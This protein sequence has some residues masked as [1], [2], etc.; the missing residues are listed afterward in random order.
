MKDLIDHIRAAHFA[1]LLV[2]LA[3]YVAVQ[4]P[5]KDAAE[6]A[7]KDALGIEHLI[8]NWDR[9]N[10]Q[11]ASESTKIAQLRR[12]GSTVRIT[13]GAII[14]KGKPA[15]QP[16]RFLDDGMLLY[17][18][19]NHK[20]YWLD[21]YGLRAPKNLDEFSDFWDRTFPK[22]SQLFSLD[23]GSL[24]CDTDVRRD[25]K[26]EQ[27]KAQPDPEAL[28]LWGG[29]LSLIDDRWEITSADK[30]Y[31]KAILTFDP[32]FAFGHCSIAATLLPVQ[33][34]ARDVAA[35]VADRVGLWTRVQFRDAF[36][37]L[38][39]RT[40]NLSA[41]S[42]HSTTEEMRTRLD[43]EGEPLEAFGAK[44]PSN[45]VLF[46]G[47]L[48]ILICQG[49]LLL[50]IRQLRQLLSDNPRQEQ[51]GGYVCLYPGAVN[52]IATLILIGG[53]ATSTLLAAWIKIWPYAFR[54]E[55]KEFY[56]LAVASAAS[57]L[58]TV[59]TIHVFAKVWSIHP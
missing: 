53:P 17:S 54:S 26:V 56:W 44:I 43:V 34:D 52:R 32:G 31:S 28:A 33:I 37:E 2:S 18:T 35:E 58:V 10:Q 42:F 23:Q 20:A 48:L 41:L 7:Y 45:Q 57:L 27:L 1:L 59:D 46:I 3:V 9:F 36:P 29:N 16:Q 6:R 14:I 40:K 21:A 15:S 12:R 4:Q 19:D 55:A 25:I 49:Y 38:S 50:H 11:L 39:D 24:R 8:D 30:P 47:P 22:I 13:L 51:P 5:L